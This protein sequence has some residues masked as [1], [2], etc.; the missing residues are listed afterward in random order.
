MLELNTDKILNGS[1]KK[2]L[3][4]EFE[5]LM[6]D[7]T[8]V[9]AVKYKEFYEN[10]SL[11]FI[12]ENSRYIFS[13]P[14]RGYPLYK[15][16]I[17]ESTLPFFCI[18]NERHKM[19]QYLFEYGH[20]MSLPQ[21]QMYDDLLMTLES[22]WNN[23]KH[24]SSLYN[25]LM[26]NS[27]SV[28]PY[29][30][31]LYL[32]KTRNDKEALNR[33]SNFFTESNN[34]NLMDAFNIFIDID[35]KSSELYEYV[36]ESY[37]ENPS[38]KSDFALNTYTINVIKRMMRD[39][40]FNESFNKIP[41][42]NL[43]HMIQGISNA[44]EDEIIKEYNTEVLKESDI[45]YSNPV[46]SINKI[47][48]DE[49]FTE[50]YQDEYDKEKL[51]RLECEKAVVDTNLS[52]VLF[53]VLSEGYDERSVK[54]HIVESICIEST[55]IEKIPQINEEVLS[56]LESKSLELENEISIITEKYFKSDGSVGEVIGKSL[57]FAAS[58]EITSTKYR[59]D[60]ET[61]VYMPKKKS[62]EEHKNSV[63]AKKIDSDDE[64]EDLDEDEIEAIKREEKR[65]K[66]RDRDASLTLK[67]ADYNDDL[68]T[69]KKQP[70]VDKPEKRPLMQRIQNKALDTNVKFKRKMADVK[71]SS[72]DAKNAVKASAKIPMNV[73]NAIKS[74]VDHWEE[75]DDNK[76]K[77]YMM[78]PGVRKR[79]FRAL[80]LAI[81]HGALFAI[82]P[83]MNAVLFICQLGSKNKDR[84]I[85]NEL[86]RELEVEIKVMD[87]K[88]E[89]SKSKGDDKQKYQLMRK[90]E[91]LNAE[92]L[93]VKTNSKFI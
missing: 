18:E 12:L 33:L 50:L 34:L 81:A 26:E 49:M 56:L 5:N 16:I 54:N 52:F 84:R 35:E 32:Y 80:K 42:I 22:K 20:Q 68:V 74:E 48:E 11:S 55:E 17:E 85:Q 28:I 92:L 53:D 66:K 83:L 7:Y 71:R 61:P 30:N 38:T 75:A 93:R 79:Y 91:Q 19:S 31:D 27:D 72:V 1:S 65:R 69:E 62:S 60:Y 76:R 14:M 40:Y 3:I 78:K 36:L 59:K 13:E 64:Y 57:G 2:I 67:T 86:I 6:K 45:H 70:K 41:N 46:N 24:S 77:E 63:K 43:R 4:R 15:K 9:N 21:K 51:H 37:V 90:R 44:N 29:Y 87:E 73:T 23:I 39:T 89:D 58:D 10:E 82:N 47:F 25:V 88:I 8:K